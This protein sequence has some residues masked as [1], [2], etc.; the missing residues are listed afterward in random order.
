M[1]AC[2][3]RKPLISLAEE[4]KVTRTKSLETTKLNKLEENSI[5]LSQK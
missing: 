1:R 3:Y 4:T 5:Y 2:H